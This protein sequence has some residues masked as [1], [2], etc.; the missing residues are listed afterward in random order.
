MKI[1]TIINEN[2]PKG[3]L[4]LLPP[5]IGECRIIAGVAVRY[6]KTEIRDGKEWHTFSPLTDNEKRQMAV[7]NGFDIT[8]TPSDFPIA[9]HP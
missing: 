3:T 1:D 2:I 7:L 6:R 4:Y 5:W 8:T 9:T